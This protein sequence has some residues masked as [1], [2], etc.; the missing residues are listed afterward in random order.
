MNN[1]IHT[2]GRSDNGSATIIMIDGSK[3]L[4]W[5]ILSLL[6]SAIAIGVS[7]TEAKHVGEKLT[8]TTRQYRLLDNDWQEMNAYIAA[9]GI[10]RDAQGHYY[11]EDTKHGRP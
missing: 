9:H 6:L 7:L 3:L 2:E 11:D 5:L 8:D 1:P 10:R 4:P